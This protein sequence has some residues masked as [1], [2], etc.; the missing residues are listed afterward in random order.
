MDGLPH[1]CPSFFPPQILRP[2]WLCQLQR[3]SRTL[4][5]SWD[6]TDVCALTT[7]FM[8]L[9]RPGN[10]EFIGSRVYQRCRVETHLALRAAGTSSF[11]SVSPKAEHFGKQIFKLISIRSEYFQ[12]HS[13]VRTTVC[14]NLIVTSWE[15]LGT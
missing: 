15:E 3:T 12:V 4:G 7:L 13:C 14:R 8:E 11:C 10:L 1:T 2:S 9:R 6:S 5:H